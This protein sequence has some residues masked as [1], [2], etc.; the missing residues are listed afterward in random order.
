MNNSSAGGSMGLGT[1]LAIIFTVLKLMGYIS[2]SWV[3]VLCP[4][5]IP[6][7]FCIICLFPLLL[8]FFVGKK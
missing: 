6:L 7:I 4:I 1:L 3:W 8:I 5:W 2:W